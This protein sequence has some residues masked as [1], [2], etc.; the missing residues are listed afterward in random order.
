MKTQDFF[1]DLKTIFTLYNKYDNIIV[2][3]IFNFLN[4]FI[5]LIDILIIINKTIYR[6]IIYTHIFLLIVSRTHI[7]ELKHNSANYFEKIMANDQ[8]VSALN[9]SI[10]FDNKKIKCL[11]FNYLHHKTLYNNRCRLPLLTKFL[12]T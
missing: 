5:L 11:L 3:I 10:L 2:S 6:N 4:L 7:I 1:C 8:N 12:L 9:I